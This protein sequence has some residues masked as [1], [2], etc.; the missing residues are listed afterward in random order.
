MKV[1]L[2]ESGNLGAGG[3]YFVITALVSDNTKR[4]RNLVRN[5]CKKSAPEDVSVLDELKG[6]ELGFPEKQDFL[7]R[8]SQKDDF[9]CSYIVADKRHIE[10]RIME[11]KNICYNYL[12]AHLLKPILKGA[13][14]D[15]EIV[16]DNH[17]TKVASRNSLAE[18]IKLEAYSKWGVSHKVDV[19]YCDSHRMYCLQAVD[20][21]SN[22]VFSKYA[23]S[24]G[25]LYN[26]LQTKYQHKVRFPC[27]K[28]N[29]THR[30][31][32]SMSIDIKLNQV[33]YV[34]EA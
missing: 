14:G 5:C 11:D 12:S 15:I 26:L 19:Q 24:N 16:F 33:Q 27:Q 20:I 25:H 17:T 28:F 2:D 1:Y 31:I 13:S 4:I 9:T 23:Y 10:P 21:V 29:T 7:N 22:S 3:R 34:D 8:L 32:H 6:F 18:Y 30:L